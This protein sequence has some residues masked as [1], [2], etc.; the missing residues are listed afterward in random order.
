MPASDEPIYH[1][2][3][4]ILNEANDA[5]IEAIVEALKRRGKRSRLDDLNFRDM[6]QT[7]TSQFNMELPDVHG[8]ARQMVRNLI[9]QHQPNIPPDHL[10]ALLDHYVP[11]PET[12]GR[13]REGQIPKDILENMIRQFLDY[14]KG[15]MSAEE[16]R[17]LR[18][19]MPQWPEE[20][21]EVFSE[22]TRRLIREA[23][24]RG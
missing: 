21:W 7:I 23:I 17:E 15:R 13:R 8:M 24:E 11:N 19:V 4:Y 6:A 5:E 22:D 9:L 3:D 16:D 18:A 14:S 12:A 1:I 2:V 20:Y 10:D